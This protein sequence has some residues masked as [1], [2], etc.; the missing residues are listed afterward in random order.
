MPKVSDVS[1]SEPQ[2]AYV[3]SSASESENSELEVENSEDSEQSESEQIEPARAERE[4]SEEPETTSSD[5][6]DGGDESND[7]DDSDGADGYDSDDDDNIVGSQNTLKRRPPS[8]EDSPEDKALLIH[9][10]RQEKRAK[11]NHWTDEEKERLFEKLKHGR[12]SL[13]EIAKHVGPGKSLRHVAEYIEH[14]QFWSNRLEP[15]FPDDGDDSGDGHTSAEEMMIQDIDSDGGDCGEIVN[16]PAVH[17]FHRD[18]VRNVARQYYVKASFVVSPILYTDLASELERFLRRIITRLIIKHTSNGTV[19]LAENELPQIVASKLDV[20]QAIRDEGFGEDLRM[21]AGR[22]RSAGYTS[23]LASSP[24]EYSYSDNDGSA[25]LRDFIIDDDPVYKCAAPSSRFGNGDS[26]SDYDLSGEDNG[27]DED[28][29]VDVRA[30]E[31]D[32]GESD[33]IHEEPTATGSS[34]DSD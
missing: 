27:S 19:V 13:V 31:T 34:N 14:M 1:Q 23:K 30:S 17:M 12:A 11:R 6:G 8:P 4:Q 26:D 3:A 28:A 21:S 24:V 32:P 18:M 10:Q 2:V 25:A 5:G 29:S 22:A 33:G 15:V 20:R 9:Q 7:S 16:H